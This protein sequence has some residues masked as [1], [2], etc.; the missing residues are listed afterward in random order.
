[1]KMFRTIISAGAAIALASSVALGA[2]FL[3]NGLPVAGG[4]QYPSTLPLTGAE[5]VPADTNLT[6]GLNPASEAITTAQLAAFGQPGSNPRNYLDNGAM[7]INQQG[8][9]VITG[10]TT[11]VSA[12]QFAADRWFIDTNVGSGAGRGQIITASPAPPTGFINSVKV[13]RTSGALLQPVCTI[14]E[15]S[16]T[17]ATQLAGKNVVVSAYL[18]A[19]AGLTSTGS[20]VNMYVFTGT[21]NDQGL[22]TLTASPAI[23]PAWTGIAIAGS[24][25]ATTTTT[26]A[27]AYSASIA[28][29]SAT[30]EVAVAY[31]FTPVGTA[32]GVTDGFAITG[33]QLEV[34]NG[35]GIVAPSP[36]EFQP[37]IYDL[38]EAQRYFWQLNEPATGAA[39]NGMCQAVGATSNICNVFLPSIMRGSV[40][41]ITIG[42]AGTFKVNIAGTPTTIAS[43]VASTCSTYACAVTAG[44][45]NTAGQAEL[46]TGGGGSGIWTV[47]SDVVM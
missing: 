36:F 16:S 27:R 3:T 15:I 11:T 25:A 43:P 7:R 33:A 14:Q 23:T 18:A 42:T 5:T 9:G 46:L 41:T 8:T 44:N 4:S 17:R 20:V 24:Y 22:A 32:S 12:L 39:L 34:V 37:Y 29:P 19:L 26:F 28:I 35:S 10:G 47:S 30:T 40:P 31:C 45:T 13:Y 38:R 6:Q 1:M 2:G 21:G